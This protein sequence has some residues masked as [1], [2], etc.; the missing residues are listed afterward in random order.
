VQ[1]LEHK[2]NKRQLDVCGKARRKP[3]L[4]RPQPFASSDTHAPNQQNL[5]ATATLLGGSKD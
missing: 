5:V 4:L 3:A 2:Q 1:S